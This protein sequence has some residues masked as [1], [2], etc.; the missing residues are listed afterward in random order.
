MS[1]SEHFSMPV[2]ERKTLIQCDFDSTIAA[3]DVSFQILD[4]FADGDWR[5]V[6]EEYREGRISVG[7]FSS[8]TFA[9]VKADKP[10][11]LR[12]ILKEKRARIRPGFQELL[13][14]CARRGFKFV[15][16]S[17]GLSFY[18]E[19]ILKD[20]GV[21]GV[22]VF[23][24]ETEFGPEGLKVRYIGP[25]GG[26][27]EDNF[28]KAYVEFFRSQGYRVIYIGDGLSDRIPASQAD[29]IFARDDLLIYCREKN[30]NHTPFDDLNDVVRGLELLASK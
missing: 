11:L 17:N 6:L 13:A 23:A 14:Y 3:D 24:A 20:I 25:D 28:K 27:L 5:Q 1:G 9:M 26:E 19:A 22:E 15:I 10:T 12:F 29:Y 21:D 16:V 30:L 4:A 8:R 18:I 2:E 7:V